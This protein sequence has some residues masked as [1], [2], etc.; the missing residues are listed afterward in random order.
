MESLPKL[1][2]K[3][4]MIDKFKDEIDDFKNEKINGK[5]K[6]NIQIGLL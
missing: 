1:I 6:S 5:M 4:E 3:E 2:T